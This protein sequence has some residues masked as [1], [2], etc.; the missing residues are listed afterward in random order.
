[1]AHYHP[2]S[3]Q[4]EARIRQQEKLARARRER[5]AQLARG[6][7]SR[8]HSERSSLPA[9]LAQIVVTIMTALT[10]WQT[11]NEQRWG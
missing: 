8:P 10:P 1:M 2:E 5:Q 9:R 11:K 7:H 6:A 3:Y 4:A